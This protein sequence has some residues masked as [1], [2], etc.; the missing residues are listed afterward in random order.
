[1][2]A[3]LISVIVPVYK[4]EAYLEKCV[5]SI[6][7]QSYKNLEI[8]LVDD[9]SPDG[10]G[11]ICDRYAQIDQRI[12]VV[13]KENGGLSDA[14]NAGLDIC[15]GKFVTFIDSDDWV[16]PEYVEYL[17]SLIRDHQADLSICEFRY[18]TEAGNEMNKPS[19]DH[20]V[21]VMN[22]EEALRNL[23]YGKMYFDSAWA[24]MYRVSDFKDIRYPKGKWYE[25]IPTTYRVMLRAEKL[26]FGKKALYNYLYRKEAI[27][28]QGFN[29]KRLDAMYFVE[30]QCEDLVRNYPELQAACSLRLFTEYV[31]IYKNICTTSGGNRDIKKLIYHKIKKCRRGLPVNKLSLKMKAYYY[32]A[33]FGMHPFIQLAVMETRFSRK[34]KK[35]IS[36]Q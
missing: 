14:R 15:R 4:V 13:H 20:S 31:Y 19:D 16:E 17:Y 11:E 8:I 22:T 5:D 23:C 29:A 32:V 21:V 10:C 1:M 3:D 12:V 6:L 24:K 18:V 34:R 26:V 9:G 30:K 7:A 27:S 36:A 25:D 35:V 28:K 33:A 2:N